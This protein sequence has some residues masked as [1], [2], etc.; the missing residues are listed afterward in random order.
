MFLL[1]AVPEVLL[2]L[3]WV[4][5]SD[6][7]CSPT[8]FYEN[9]WI[10]RFPGLSIDVEHSQKRGAHILN[11]YAAST[12]G[13]C[14]R[15]CCILKDVSCNL[16]VFYYETNIQD[17]NC[18][19]MYCP[20][21]ESCIVKPTGGVVL[22]NITPGLDPDLLVFEKLSFKDI[23]TR[24]SFSKRERHGGARVAGLETNQDGLSSPSFL[25]LEAPPLTTAPRPAAERSS[26]SSGVAAADRNSPVTF[27]ALASATDHSVKA[28]EVPSGRNSS[29]TASDNARA[30]PV[31]GLAPIQMASPSPSVV[32]PNTSKHLNETKVYSG[33]NNS[34]DE[35]GQQPVQEVTGRG[36]WLLPTVL[37]SLL[38]FTCCCCSIFWATGCSWKKRGRY[39]PGQKGS[40]S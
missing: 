18:I 11:I 23:N 33:R 25:L 31:S 38:A 3:G 30:S 4:C 36:T 7:L 15:A 2:L 40:N 24:S 21:L 22:Y 28:A 34:S 35:E 37:C 32:L 5:R 6:G 9:C 26:R 12:A 8:T 39:K 1:V 29:T 10:R 14:S 16:A 19:H 17:M 27:M 20:A 13:H